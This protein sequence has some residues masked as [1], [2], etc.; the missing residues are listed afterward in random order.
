MII[1]T[2]PI[3][4]RGPYAGGGYIAGTADGIVTVAGQPARRRVFLLD[5][6]T[7]KVVADTWSLKNGHYMLPELNADKRY[8]V[9]AR[10]YLRQYEP[11]TYDYVEP[12][13]DLTIKQQNELW[14]SWQT[15]D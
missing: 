8:I 5:A 15:T 6:N 3:T 11:V 1:D 14:Q 7:F 2:T 9:F 10:D 13:T 12:A 4:S